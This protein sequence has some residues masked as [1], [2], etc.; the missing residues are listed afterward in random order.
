MSWRKG[1][2]RLL[3]CSNAALPNGRLCRFA[4]AQTSRCARLLTARCACLVCLTTSPGSYNAAATSAWTA[5]STWCSMV[6][7][8]QRWARGYAESAI[9]YTARSC[10]RGRAVLNGLKCR[11]LPHLNS[12]CGG[13][14]GRLQARVHMPQPVLAVRACWQ[15]GSDCQGRVPHLRGAWLCPWSYRNPASR[16]PSAEAPK[17]LLPHTAL[18]L[19]PRQH[20]AAGFVS[21]RLGSATK[22]RPQPF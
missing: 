12:R 8:G 11:A 6:S 2:R 21:V 3:S 19:A 14:E 17:R 15:V 22:S 18:V 16:T 4:W 9:V 5:T 1:Q 10:G 7:R 20:R 13:V